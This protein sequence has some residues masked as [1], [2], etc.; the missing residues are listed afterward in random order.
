[1]KEHQ[2]MVEKLSGTEI[3]AMLARPDISGRLR[4]R[5]EFESAT[6][7]SRRVHSRLRAG[8]SRRI[9]RDKIIVRIG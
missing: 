5:L 2:I 4:D 6:R 7:R 1:M 9:L 3:Q 8:L